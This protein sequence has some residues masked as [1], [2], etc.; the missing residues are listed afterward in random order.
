MGEFVRVKG[1]SRTDAGVHARSQ[2]ATIKLNSEHAPFK[3]QK[4]LNALTPESLS[5]VDAVEVDPEFH[6]R[7]EV[8]GKRYVYQIHSGKFPPALEKNYFWW[9]KQ[10]PDLKLMHQASRIL[11][12]QKDFSGFRSRNCCSPNTI[13]TITSIEFTS[14]TYQ[15]AQRIQIS[16][17]GDGFLKNMVRI[18]VGS[19]VNVGTGKLNMNALEEALLTKQR[20]LIGM[21]APAHGLV[22]DHVFTRQK[23]F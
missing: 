20:K 15:N 21:T 17:T 6:L 10:I 5:V 23:I 2:L 18:I 13:K 4:G 9:L 19:L 1:C 3:I 12:G 14:Y 22:L 8:A 11:I 16:V 7:K